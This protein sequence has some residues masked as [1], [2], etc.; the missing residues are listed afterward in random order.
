MKKLFTFIIDW[1]AYTA[2]CCAGIGGGMYFLDSLLLAKYSSYLP[3]WY[4]VMAIIIGAWLAK[5]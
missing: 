5:D 4:L 2:I 3:I 1:F